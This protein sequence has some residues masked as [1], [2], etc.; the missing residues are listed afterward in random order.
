[1]HTVQFYD[2]FKIRKCVYVFSPQKRACGPRKQVFNPQI[3]DCGPR[4]KV[5]C[6]TCQTQNYMCAFKPK[7]SHTCVHLRSFC[8]LSWDKV[9]IRITWKCQ[10]GICVASF[11]T[12]LKKYILTLPVSFPLPG[13]FDQ[14]NSRP[15]VQL[16]RLNAMLWQQ[17]LPPPTTNVPLYICKI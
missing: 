1:M 11:K 10:K 6:P 17:L 8:F 13:V 3:Q 4:K 9:W 16:I 2:L 15:L 14:W 12:T 5:F 7:F